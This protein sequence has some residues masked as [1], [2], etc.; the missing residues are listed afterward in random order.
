[1]PG[2]S[3]HVVDVSRGVV[4]AGMR[5]DVFALA[6]DGARRLLA[7]G[8][9]SAKGTLDDPALAKYP[10]SYMAE[11]GWWTLTDT[12]AAAF[13]AYLQKGGFVI[14][15]DFREPPVGGGG[16]ANFEA[17]MRRVLPEGRFIDLDPSSP[18]FHS[19]FEINSFDLIPQSYDEGRPV[20]RGLFENNDPTKRLMAIANFNTDVSDFWEF[21]M[22]GFKPIEE[23]N[24][25][26]KLGVNYIIYGMTH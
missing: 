25:A 7:R 6:P 4:A 1:V 22:T 12:E 2:L 24:E 16:W 15:D 26:Y 13:R 18:I 11:A 5:I 19:F 23:S 9:L 10:V 14:F 20:I 3:I 8:T 17:N 21:A